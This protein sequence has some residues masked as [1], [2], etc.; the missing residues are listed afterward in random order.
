M[1]INRSAP[2]NFY[3]DNA[4]KTNKN[5]IYKNLRRSKC[6][7]CNFSCSNFDY[8]NLRGAHFKKCNFFRC[9]FKGAEFVGSNLKG[10]K[11]KEAKFEDTIFEEVN[12]D[13][14]DFSDA[15]FKNTIFL[16]CDTTKA[17][18]LNENTKGIR[19]FDEVPE[20]EISEDLENI[21][22]GLMDNQYIKKS[23]V[24]DTKDGNINKLTLLRLSEIFDEKTLIEGFHY[25]K[26]E[27]D[28]DFYTLSYV[29]RLI[30]NMHN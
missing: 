8:A 27:I 6:Y 24:F 19:I 5:F 12:L 15:K 21:V 14:V 30:E 25:I 2:E 3:Y 22:T 4:E 9:S 26:Y 29:I 23:R 10:C 13:G 7:N 17:K 20:L 18:N 16:G 1:S 11:F 28:R